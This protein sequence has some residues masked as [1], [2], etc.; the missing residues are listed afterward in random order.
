MSTLLLVLAL[1]CTSSETTPDGTPAEAAPAEA[2]APEAAAPAASDDGPPADSGS[3][4]PGFI[5]A[6]HVLIAYN[7]AVG[8]P[9]G[10]T[11]TPAQARA[12]AEEVRA[13]A[14]AGES[15]EEL[16]RTMSDDPSGPRGGD[17][18]A[19]DKGRMVPDFEAAAFALPENGISE[20]V[21]T[22][23]GFHVI[24]RYPLREVHIAHVLVQYAGLQRTASDRSPEEARTRAEQARDRL[25]AGEDLAA[26]V[27][28]LSDGPTRERQ[29]DLGWFQRGQMLPQFDSVAFALAPGEVSDVVETPL[30]YHVLVRLE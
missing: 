3:A 30:G 8:A 17:L 7:G 6:R 21:E 29:G 5:A 22:R 10:V 12:R 18:G 24:Q 25:R 20:V 15:F 13:R 26:V 23:F 11:R 4:R 19:F 1:A 14:V 27:A 28:E 2:A 16:A 9:E